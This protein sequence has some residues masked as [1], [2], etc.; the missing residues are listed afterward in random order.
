[1]RKPN[2]EIFDFVIQENKLNPQKTLFIDDSPQHIEGA[3]KTGL[4]SYYLD[5]NRSSI[6]DL[7]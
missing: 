3:L 4:N 1:M 6:L 5:V 2:R 7:M